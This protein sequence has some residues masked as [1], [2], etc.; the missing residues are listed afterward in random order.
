MLSLKINR[1]AG[2]VVV[3]GLSSKPLPPR[4][5]R[6]LWNIS[7]YSFARSL[8]LLSIPSEDEYKKIIMPLI[9]VQTDSCFHILL[10]S[11]TSFINIIVP[12]ICMYC[13]MLDVTQFIN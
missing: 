5:V 3:N 4:L 6:A 13:S 1:L 7:N 2:H 8:K 9:P 10:T 11:L 12:S